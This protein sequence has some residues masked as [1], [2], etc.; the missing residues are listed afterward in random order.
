LAGEDEPTARVLREIIGACMCC[1]RVVQQ[2]PMLI[3]RAHGTTASN[4]KSTY[5]NVLRAMLG[6]GN[7]SSLDIATLGQRFQ[8]GRI[9]GK[10]AN[11]GDDIPDGFLRGEELSLF[12][13]LVTGDQIYT[14]VKNARGFEFRP[15]A[16]MVF[17]MNAMPRLADTTDGVFRRLAFVPF[18]NHFEPGTEGFD[19]DMAAKMTRPENLQRL[20]LMG[21]LAPHDL[22]KRHELTRIPDMEAE[23]EEVKTNNDV[24]KRWLIDS[25]I[26]AD[27]LDGRWVKDAYADFRRWCDEAGEKFGVAQVVFTRRV[28]A[29]LATL[30]TVNT[31]DR[32][33]GKRGRKFVNTV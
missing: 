24:V 29:T 26:D 33:V 23:V 3:G 1:R 15:S 21:L 27:D 13:K 30:E 20:A 32:S 14:D 4:G 12:K 5:L 22:I 9:V 8:A 7:V 6:T 28:L 2:S 17:S 19:P 25:M 18:R 16:T 10:L 31:R 11:L